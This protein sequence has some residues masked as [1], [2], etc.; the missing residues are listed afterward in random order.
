TD[1]SPRLLAAMDNTTEGEMIPPATLLF[2]LSSP[3]SDS[4]PEAVRIPVMS[5]P[6][7]VVVGHGMVGHYFLE[8]LVERD[9]H[10]HYH[11]VVFGEERYEAYDRVHLS[12][13]FSGRSAASLSLV[14]DGFFAESGIELR[15]TSEIVA[16]DRERQCVCDA[17]GRETAYDK[18]V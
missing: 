7:L 2:G 18:L 15:S 12:E 3:D 17:Q 16:I 6:I 5:K 9:L 1:D 13:Y 4:Q 14:K 11:I 8:Q 10:Q